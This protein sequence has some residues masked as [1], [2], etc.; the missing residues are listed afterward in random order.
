M[1]TFAAATVPSIVFLTGLLS[2]WLVNELF[3]LSPNSALLGMLAS[4][5]S[6]AMIGAALL[7]PMHRSLWWRVPAALI[8][9]VS[10]T[11]AF[12]LIVWAFGRLTR[13]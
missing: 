11:A 8:F 5:V 7:P 12:A 9:A 3:R 13:W 4:A 6:G 10:Q 2:I 1:R